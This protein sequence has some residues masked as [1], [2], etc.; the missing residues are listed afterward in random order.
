MSS[1]V[2]LPPRQEQP[3]SAAYFVSCSK[4]DPETTV[5]D[6]EIE[7][8]WTSISMDSSSFHLSFDA[9]DNHD[10]ALTFALFDPK[11][12]RYEWDDDFSIRKTL[13]ICTIQ[14]EDDYDRS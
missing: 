10:P 5:E 6:T 14:E 4:D 8:L 1:V 3:F 11:Q 13:H 2:L 9:H 12:R 7:S